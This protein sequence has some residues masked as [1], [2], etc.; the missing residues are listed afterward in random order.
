MIKIDL[1]YNEKSECDRYDGC[2][3]VKGNIEQITLELQC[4]INAFLDN[5]YLIP[6]INGVIAYKMPEITESRD[7]IS[8]ESIGHIIDLLERATNANT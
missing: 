6:V 8:D 1:D 2:C 4:I 3:V 7:K 5:K